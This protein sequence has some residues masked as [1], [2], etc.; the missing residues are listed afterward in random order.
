MDVATQEQLELRNQA[1]RMYGGGG[2]Q[3]VQWGRG[4][5]VLITYKVDPKKKNNLIEI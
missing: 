2:A 1:W 5:R 3:E 4:S